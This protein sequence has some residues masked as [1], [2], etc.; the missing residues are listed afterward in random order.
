MIEVKLQVR[1]GRVV[2]VSSRGHAEGS[3][4]GENIL[5]AAVS[6][7]IRSFARA[8]EDAPG[9]ESEGGAPEPGILDLTVLRIGKEK[10]EWFEGLSH[11]LVRGL[12]D[13]E[14]EYPEKLRIQTRVEEE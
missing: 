7:L 13:L 5:C 12:R 11:F 4:A 1:D 9:I 14:G 8:V 6:V 10:E 2:R 3:P